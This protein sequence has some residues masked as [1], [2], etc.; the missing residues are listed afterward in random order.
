MK[1]RI[2][3]AEQEVAEE[4]SMMQEILQQNAQLELDVDKK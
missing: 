1:V 2:D 4:G 3:S